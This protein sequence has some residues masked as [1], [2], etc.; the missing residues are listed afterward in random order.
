M[1]KKKTQH[2]HLDLPES[3]DNPYLNAR[4]QWDI[5]Y[6]GY[7]QEAKI[8]KMT[9]FIS[10]TITAIAVI[11]MIWI[12]SLSKFVPYVIEVDKLGEAVT[13]K[14]AIQA[15]IVDQKIIKKQLAEFIVNLRT[16]TPDAQLQK[17]M[18]IK[19]YG[20]LSNNDPASLFLTG[21]FQ[22]EQHSPFKRA[23]TNTVHVDITSVL[24]R[25]EKT[26]QI[27]WTETIRTR[28]GNVV[29]IKAM[30]ALLTIYIHPSETHKQFITNPMGI[31][32][33]EISWTQINLNH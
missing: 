21:Y 3:K 6:G 1:F 31:Y 28:E 12:G 23:I 8:W 19:A 24:P 17:D 11:G 30:E 18:I 22:E 20:L 15:K 32:V 4:Q 33:K 14:P 25:T 26:W 9:A 2:N 29:E 13:T 10:L 16:V 27:A 5:R 7:I